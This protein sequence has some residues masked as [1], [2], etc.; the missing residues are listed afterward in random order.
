MDESFYV[1]MLLVLAACLLLGFGI[2]KLM[3]R[4]MQGELNGLLFDGFLA[5]LN[6]ICIAMVVFAVAGFGLAAF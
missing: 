1:G 4:R 3:S 2:W 5:W 6:R